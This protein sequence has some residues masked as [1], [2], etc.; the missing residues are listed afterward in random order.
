MVFGCS[1]PVTYWLDLSQFLV[2]F[3]RRACEH[4]FPV[5]TYLKL[6]FCSLDTGRTARFTLC[7]LAYKCGLVLYVVFL[8]NLIPVLIF[9]HLQVIRSFC[10]KFLVL[11]PFYFYSLSSFIVTVVLEFPVA[12]QSSAYWILLLCLVGPFVS[13][14]LSFGL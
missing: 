11:F 14:T 7:F 13:E 2:D 3:Y 1:F 10:L 4:N 8:R 9:L 12:G 5:L 6:F